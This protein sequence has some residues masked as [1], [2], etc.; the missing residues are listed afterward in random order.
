MLADSMTSIKAYLYERAV[1]PLLGSLIV[2]WAAWNYQFILLWVSGMK[3]PE[4]LRYVHVL[5]SSDY[6]IYLQGMLF[7]FLTSMAYLFLFTYPAEWVYR[8][9]LY[10]QGILKEWKV[11]NEDNDRLSV[12]KSRAIR[13]QLADAEREAEEQIERK[14]RAIESRDREIEDLRSQLSD[15]KKQVEEAKLQPEP[16]KQEQTKQEAPKRITLTEKVEQLIKLGV[17]KD[18]KTE[19]EYFANALISIYKNGATIQGHILSSLFSDRVKAKYYLD[20]L[21]H[22]KLADYGGGSYSLPH[23]VKGVFVKHF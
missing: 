16:P 9:S 2:S 3:F 17:S 8:F 6:E 7:P 4:K 20:E 21:V 18:P 10:R 23:E 5:Y 13:Q 22:K 1:S 11:K 12:E 14:D 19:D 15:I